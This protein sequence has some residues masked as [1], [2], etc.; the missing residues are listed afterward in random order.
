M[1]KEADVEILRFYFSIWLKGL[2]IITKPQHNRSVNRKSNPESP[3][4]Y[5]EILM[6]HDDRYIRKIMC[7]NPVSGSV[8]LRQFVGLLRS[9]K[10][11]SK[12]E[13][14]CFLSHASP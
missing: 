6:S 13:C 5:I 10:T 3:V 7:S 4:H 11:G 8:I 9:F 1:W 2:K 12:A 14:L